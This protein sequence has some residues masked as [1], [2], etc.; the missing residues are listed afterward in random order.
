[1]ESKAKLQRY[2]VAIGAVLVSA[3]IILKQFM[4]INDAADGLIRGVGIGVMVVALIFSAK[5][6]QLARKV[7]H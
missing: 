4:A 5:Q 7:G 1:M 3:P 2:L 6:R